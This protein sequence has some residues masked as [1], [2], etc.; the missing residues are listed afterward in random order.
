M[1]RLLD[2][3]RR[4]DKR[5][6]FRPIDRDGHGFYAFIARRIESD[7]PL[8][9]FESEPVPA[10]QEPPEDMPSLTLMVLDSL[11]DDSE[12]LTTM[13]DHGEVAPHGLALVGEEHIIA[14]I[15][16]LLGDGL[17]EPLEALG[18]DD[19]G[20]EQAWFRMTPAGWAEFRD[21]ADVLERYWDAHPI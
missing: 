9:R 17:I 10:T 6:P 19:A 16:L 20:L 21:A 5:S 14:A 1:R 18:V 11:A 8:R 3:N 15:R 7:A 12:T 4:S 2:A 13:R